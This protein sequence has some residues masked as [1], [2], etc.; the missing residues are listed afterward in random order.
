MMLRKLNTLYLIFILF[1]G[2]FSIYEN[3]ESF[4]WGSFIL[5]VLCGLPIATCWLKNK[6]VGPL[7]LSFSIGGFILNDIY[8]VFDVERLVFS[9]LIFGTL[10]GFVPG[11][12]LNKPVSI[13][14]ARNWCIND[15]Y[16]SLAHY[17]ERKLEKYRIQHEPSKH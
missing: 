12:H 7:L 6:W 4:S 11:Y 16:M 13:L 9:G 5:G 1:L 15:G 8:N 3:I 17:F 14:L 2:C 10:V